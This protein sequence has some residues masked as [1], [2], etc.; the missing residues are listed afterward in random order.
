MEEI[1]SQSQKLPFNSI[2]GG[3]GSGFCINLTLPPSWMILVYKS[4]QIKCFTVALMRI[5]VRGPASDCVSA[6]A[7]KFAKAL[8][9]LAPRRTV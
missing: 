5:R 8:V 6:T 1:G 2:L 9:V 7:T 4:A 3:L